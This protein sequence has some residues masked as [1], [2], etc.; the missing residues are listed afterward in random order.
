[1]VTI[2]VA[3]TAV[4]RRAKAIALDDTKMGR[5]H[6]ENA[7]L[8]ETPPLESKTPEYQDKLQMATHISCQNHI[9]LHRR[10]W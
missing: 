4:S 8:L 10:I 3:A 2:T 6:G 5:K 7:L 9:F 1:V